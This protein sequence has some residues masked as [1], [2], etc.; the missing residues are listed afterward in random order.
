MCICRANRPS[1]CRPPY[2]THALTWPPT[3]PT[4]LS[5]NGTANSYIVDVDDVNALGYYF[6]A[7][8]AGNGVEA[9]PAGIYTMLG[10]SSVFYPA[11]ATLSGDG[12]SVALNQNDCISD[13][14][15]ADGKISFKAT[16]TEGNAKVVLTN[17]GSNVWV[18][19]IWCTDNP[20]AITIATADGSQ[21]YTLLDRNLGATAVSG[22]ND[23]T[24]FGLYYMFG[25]PIGY[26]VAEWEQGDQGGW[27]MVDELTS[28]NKPFCSSEYQYVWFNCSGSTNPKQAASFLWGA[29]GDGAG[30]TWGA[31][32]GRKPGTTSFKQLYD[33]CPVGYKVMAWDVLNGRTTAA[34]F[35]SNNNDYVTIEG[36][37]GTLYLPFNGNVFAGGYTWMTHN[38]MMY[39]WT[40]AFNNSNMAW[41]YNLHTGFDS[42]YSGIKDHIATRGMGVRCM[43][44]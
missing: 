28:P 12:V 30:T 15:Y 11:S 3:E 44:E 24:V 27:R 4:N 10:L 36:T 43:A 19:H 29:Y 35:S 2:P 34:S 33:P 6:D 38:Y 1:D 25:D 23:E 42:T 7:T 8:K 17:G 40:S 31:T 39:L 22:A 20:G 14:A 32:F 16:G 5:K 9:Q 13:V 18:W 41:C 26:T 37:N 21:N